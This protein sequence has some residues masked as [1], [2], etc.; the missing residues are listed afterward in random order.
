MFEERADRIG[1][2]VSDAKESGIYRCRVLAHV[3][4]GAFV[5]PSSVVVDLQQILM[6]VGMVAW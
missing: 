5:K 6:L 3:A 1:C 2:G 4:H